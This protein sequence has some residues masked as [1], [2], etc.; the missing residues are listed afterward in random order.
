MKNSSGPKDLIISQLKSI[1]WVENY[2]IK[3]IPRLEKAATSRYLKASFKGHLFATQQ[4]VQRLEKI[5]NV[6]NEKISSKKCKVME[7]I[8]RNALAGIKATDKNS[9][10]REIGL[11]EAAMA[12][13]KYEIDMY[14]GLIKNGYE[15]NMHEIISL[16]EETF[17]EE[18]E[19][20]E[21]FTAIKEDVLN[22]ELFSAKTEMIE[23]LEVAEE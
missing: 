6:L 16:L 14:T 3:I 7:E 10:L 2:L 22:D 12:I 23:E 15:F 20:E 21:T 9:L 13:E 8:I 17:I 18:K 19:A 4:H 5:F 1:Y 11:I